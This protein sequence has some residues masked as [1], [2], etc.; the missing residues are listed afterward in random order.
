[1]KRAGAC[2][3][4]VAAIALAPRGARAM[5]D[6]THGPAYVQGGVGVSFWDFPGI[7]FLG[8]YS[9]T[10]FNP[11]VE[12]GYH[13][14]GRHDGFVLALRQGFAITAVQGA[15]AGVT[16]VRGGYDL[17]FKAGSFEVNV[18]P[19]G[20]FGVGYIF[21]GL[22]PGAG[23]SAGIQGTAGIDVKVFFTKG[24][25]AYARPAELG[26]QCFHDYG[27]CAFTYAAGVGAGFAFGGS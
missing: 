23:P 13:F 10:G 2:L 25:F 15:A 24:F 18:D 22:L 11:Q 5:D 21:D 12:L 27:Q 19:F 16:L 9:W 20:T 1:M 26:F 14:S 17:A 7:R 3:V 6:S 8:S 4:A